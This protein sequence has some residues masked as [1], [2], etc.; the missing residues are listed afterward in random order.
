MIML[1]L[2]SHHNIHVAVAAVDF[3]KGIAGLIAL[4]EQVLAYDPF[5]GHIFVFRNRLRTAVKLFLYALK[6]VRWSL[7]FVV[8]GLSPASV[9]SETS[10]KTVLIKSLINCVKII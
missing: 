4:C 6:N 3:R 9:R 8:K 1:Q 5:G 2:T 7:K 10:Y